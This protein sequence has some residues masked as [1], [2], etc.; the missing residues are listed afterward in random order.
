MPGETLNLPAISL[1]VHYG[2]EE[3]ISQPEREWN[4]EEGYKERE[5]PAPRTQLGKVGR[6]EEAMS[7][8]TKKSTRKAGPAKPE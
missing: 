3:E 1:G 6:K 2:N 4:R 8:K 5:K 7:K